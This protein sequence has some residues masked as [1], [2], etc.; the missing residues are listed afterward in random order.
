[1]INHGPHSSD[2]KYRW[3]YWS[4]VFLLHTVGNPNQVQSNKEQYCT[5]QK[6]LQQPNVQSPAVDNSNVQMEIDTNPSLNPG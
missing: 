4:S 3:G 1:M 6:C 2:L 5:S